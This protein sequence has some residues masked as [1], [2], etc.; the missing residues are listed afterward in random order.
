LVL[1][2]ETVPAGEGLARAPVPL[3]VGDTREVSVG[4]ELLECVREPVGVP[5]PRADTLTLPDAREVADCEGDPDTVRD[6]E[7]V[8]VTDAEPHLLA[9]WVAV[10]EGDP[11]PERDAHSLGL[12]VA[13]GRDAVATPLDVSDGVVQALPVA[14]DDAEAADEVDTE[15]LPEGVRDTKVLRVED[16]CGVREVVVEAEALVDNVAVVERDGSDDTL[17]EKVEE[18]ESRG[19]RESPAVAL[20]LS[21][22]VSDDE[23]EDDPVP[24]SVEDT[25]ALRLCVGE[26]VGEAVAGGEHELVAEVV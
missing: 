22:I 9:V 1:L 23:D 21:E 13:L 25:A 14:A 5:L 17:T 8:G 12:A 10:P 15:A 11:E 19:V 6:R 4:S 18:R 16:A 7:G 26:T 24:E 20:W 3:S 2:C